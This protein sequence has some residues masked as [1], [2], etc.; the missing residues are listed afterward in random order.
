MT[1]APRAWAWAR[2]RA[3]AAPHGGACFPIYVLRLDAPGGRVGSS[4]GAVRELVPRP[5]E[6]AVYG[7]WGSV[8]ISVWR[9][10]HQRKPSGKREEARAGRPRDR[11]HAAHTMA[12][13]L[14]FRGTAR[15]ELRD[16]RGMDGWMD[17]RDE[18]TRRWV[19]WDGVM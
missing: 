3:V 6:K 5:I 13:S 12:V 4:L 7:G 10:P 15:G 18:W 2:S 17:G 1:A 19:G 14:S 9:R 11:P 8:C 16:G